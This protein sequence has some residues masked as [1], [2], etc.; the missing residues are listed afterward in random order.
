M[1][2]ILV[3]GGLGFIGT[4]LIKKLIKDEE[5]MIDIVDNLSN[6]S[7]N[8]EEFNNPKIKNPSLY[9]FLLKLVFFLFGE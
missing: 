4:H 1:K 8:P 6:H 9:F 7:I 5:C 3:T 2:K